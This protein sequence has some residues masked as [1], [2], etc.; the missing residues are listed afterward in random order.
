MA[1]CCL[2]MILKEQKHSQ[3][4]IEWVTQVSVSA[5]Q[6]QGGFLLGLRSQRKRA[7]LHTSSGACAEERGSHLKTGW[8]DS[9]A[10]SCEC[11][12]EWWLLASACQRLSA[13]SPEESSR[14][15][16]PRLLW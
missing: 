2:W 9:L 8:C 1:F 4:E 7:V 15:P 5:I 13:A 6:M 16:L 10:A 3:M 11:N 14:A 12:S